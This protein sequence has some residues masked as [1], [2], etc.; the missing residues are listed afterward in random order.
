MNA[1]KNRG[2]RTT[3]R[4]IK[5]LVCRRLQYVMIL[6]SILNKCVPYKKKNYIEQTLHLVKD[7]AV[8]GFN[9]GLRPKWKS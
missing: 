4:L 5:F 1:W 8:K 3:C 2:E 9:S 7:S 6:R